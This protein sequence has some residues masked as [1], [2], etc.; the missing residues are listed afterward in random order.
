[1]TSQ[2]SIEDLL[3]LEE[4]ALVHPIYFRHE[5]WTS[6][7]KKLD[8]QWTLLATRVLKREW[9]KLGLHG[10]GPFDSLFDNLCALFWQEVNSLEPRPRHP[11]ICRLEG[12]FYGLSFYNFNFGCKPNAAL[13][14][15]TKIEIMAWL[16][17]TT[18]VLKEITQYGI[19]L[20]SQMAEAKTLAKCAIDLR[21]KINKL[22]NLVN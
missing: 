3:Q 22:T 7:L 9:I 14:L 6:T 17:T 5:A 1:M 15:E 11:S 16:T 2:E 18:N 21:K 10:K 8:R 4:L 20:R 13:D 19:G 12:I